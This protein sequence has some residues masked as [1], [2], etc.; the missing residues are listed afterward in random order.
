MTEAGSTQKENFQIAD[1]KE[2]KL[3]NLLFILFRTA[4]VVEEN[5]NTFLQQAQRF[6]DQFR[7]LISERG[8][9]SIKVI[10]GR[11]FIGSHLVKFESESGA[12]AQEIIHYWRKAGIGGM[13]LDDSFKA[14]QIAKFVYLLARLKRREAIIDDAA[15][16]LMELGVEGLSLL[17]IEE[18]K[19]KS[20]L[21]VDRRIMMRRSAQVTFFKAISIVEKAMGKSAGDSG[22]D[23]TETRRV[24]HALIDRLYRDESILIELTN[25]RDFD[26][27]TYAH[28]ANVCVYSLTMGIRLGLDRQRLSLLGFSALFHDM[29]KVRLPEDLIRKPDVFDEHDWMQMQRHPILGAKTILNNSRFDIYTARAARVALEHHINNDFTGYPILSIRRPTN[30]FS[31]IVSIADTFDALLSGRVYMKKAIP[32]DEVLRKMMFQ[33]TVKF[34]AF[35]LKLFINIIGVYPAGTL[36]LLST[37]E[38]AMVSA[39]NPDN[40]VRPVIRIIGDRSGAFNEFKEVDLSNPKNSHREIVRVIDP[41]KKD[42]DIRKIILSDKLA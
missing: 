19:E 30:L 1:A 17:G 18:E 16:N 6:D 21:P 10:E 32:P 27:Y 36:V 41:K 34:D 5:N 23:N 2:T 37:D 26:E 20:I 7:M 33:M 11:I 38:L 31:R 4:Q 15:E 28:C 25:I 40:I 12:R 9:I 29:G 24:V 42:I 39:N 8:I 22:I 35:L 3:I 14:E 13:V